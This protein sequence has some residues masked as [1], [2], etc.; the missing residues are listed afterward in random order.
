MDWWSR[1][2][3]SWEVSTWLDRTFCLNALERALTISK[4]EIFNTDQGRQFTSLEFT[5]RLEAEGIRISMDSR[6]RAFDNIFIERLWRTVKYEEV[7][8]HSYETVQE[9]RRRLSDYFVFY[10]GEHL[11]SALGYKTPPGSIF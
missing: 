3:L 1:Y 10:N 8:L 9:A 2:V 6:G 4:P 7:Y 5:R 11:H